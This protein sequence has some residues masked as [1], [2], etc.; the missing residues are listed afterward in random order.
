MATQRDMDESR[1][2]IRRCR[3][4]LL[5]IQPFFGGLALRLPLVPD[6]E[7]QTI[8]T[9]GDDLLYNPKWV[10]EATIEDLRMAVARVVMACVLKH[11]TRRGDREYKRW[12]RASQMVTLPIMRQAGFTDMP[13]GFDGSI[14]RAYASLPPEDEDKKDK[15]G[16]G[17]GDGGGMGLSVAVAGGGGGK[18]DKNGDGDKSDK[19]ESSDPNG[20]GEVMDAPG[21]QN[22]GDGQGD[23]NQDGDG[24]GQGQ[25]GSGGE[26]FSNALAQAAKQDQEQKW[27]MVMHQARQL[28]KAR[29]IVP[30]GMSELVDNAHKSQV[31]WRTILRRFMLAHAQVDYTWSRPNHRFID[32]GLYMPSLHSEAMPPIVFAVD[33]SASLNTDALA[34]IWGEIRE[35]VAEVCPE[36]VTVIQ[37]DS[38][39]QD[40]S[41][42]HP[43]EL[44]ETIEI[45]GR[46]GTAFQPVFER[47]EDE[48]LPSCLIYCTDMVCREYG[49][50]PGYPVLWAAVDAPPQFLE[51]VPFG[52]VV[53][54]S[55][56]NL[57][58]AVGV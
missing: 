38:R 30:G 28:A 25:P 48:V 50:D 23:G 35:V 7:R 40:V 51:N 17:D 43:L 11:H 37:C 20:Q 5:A 18:G 55:A 31:D 41:Q 45:K 1:R 56:N 42:Y 21:T 24:D 52:E 36:F 15:D 2:R 47:M 22:K 49:P 46:G 58:V 6:S 53:E 27:D 19:P 26:G 10:L 54:V 44:P 13:G 8:A 12:Q 9:N 57:P 32:D 3:N 34:E 14:E 33:T 29:G 39:V 16:D 4:T